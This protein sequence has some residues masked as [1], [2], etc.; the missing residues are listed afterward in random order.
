MRRLDRAAMADSACGPRR[1]SKAPVRCSIIR[2]R[3]PNTCKIFLSLQTPDFLGISLRRTNCSASF[4]RTLRQ[5]LCKPRF[6]ASQ[7]WSSEHEP[8]KPFLSP[9]PSAP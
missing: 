8:D 9:G 1:Q 7:R 4:Y 3:M 6:A 2:Y 5:R